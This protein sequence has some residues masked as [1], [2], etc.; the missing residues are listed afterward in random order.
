MNEINERMLDISNYVEECYT[1]QT[2]AFAE[3]EYDYIGSVI[4]GESIR[5]VLDVGTGEGN[6]LAGLA[7]LTPQ[8]SYHAIDADGVLIGKASAKN[9]RSNIN[10][11]HRLFDSSFP[12][13][14]YDLI[15]ARFA[16]EHVP[17]VAGFIDQAYKRLKVGGKLVITEYLVDKL[18][19]E[20]PTW[21]MFRE[22]ERELYTKFGSHPDI[23]LALPKLMRTAGYSSI[24]SSFRHISPATIGF[25]DFYDLVRSYAKVYN[26]ME[27]EIWTS[28][29]VTEIVDYCN[30]AITNQDQEDILLITHTVGERHS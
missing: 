9:T 21:I 5:T 18:Q 6:F 15:I 29:I 8:V 25:T 30:H 10:F 14:E 2:K 1:A 4:R 24:R 12:R 28:Q 19:S 22:K 16:V 3:V 17:D 27:P 26:Q 13:V 11:E 23:S 7:D 20:N